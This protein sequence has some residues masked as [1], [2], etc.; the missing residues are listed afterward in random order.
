MGE[1]RD[2]GIPARVAKK[3]PALA[4]PPLVQDFF[5]TTCAGIPMSLNSPI[6]ECSLSFVYQDWKSSTITYPMREI[7]FSLTQAKDPGQ[8]VSKR[9]T[10][11]PRYAALEFF[12][13]GDN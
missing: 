6:Q 11:L 3:N 4:A 9:L 2:I 5:F 12:F 13:D 7:H 1:Y 8:A 10:Q